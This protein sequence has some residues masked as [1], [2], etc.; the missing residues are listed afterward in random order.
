M[1]EIKRIFYAYRII[2]RNL[3]SKDFFLPTK[4]ANSCRRHRT[5]ARFF[6]PM[7]GGRKLNVKKEG[8]ILCLWEWRK[9][10]IQKL[11]IK[12]YWNQFMNNFEIYYHLYMLISNTQKFVPYKGLN[13]EWNWWLFLRQLEAILKVPLIQC[14]IYKIFRATFIIFNGCHFFFKQSFWRFR[15]NLWICIYKWAQFLIHR[16]INKKKKEKYYSQKIHSHNMRFI[17]W[18]KAIR[19]V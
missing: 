11:P 17:E 8:N 12:T 15:L 1:E 3:L 10:R 16:I 2:E 13:R 14:F 4:I 7:N 6:F 5:E 9:L 19:K 18:K